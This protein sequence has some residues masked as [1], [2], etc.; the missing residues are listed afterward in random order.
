M[1]FLSYDNHAKQS[2]KTEI[3]GTPFNTSHLFVQTW[4]PD[5]MT[6]ILKDPKFAYALFPW[7]KIINISSIVGSKWKCY[8]AFTGTRLDGLL[9]LSF[10]TQ[11]IIAFIATAPWNYFTVGKMRRI[12]SGFIYF[13]IKTSLYFHQGGEF[14]LNAL[15]DA[16]KFYQSRGMV[17][18]GKVNKEG[19]K[20]YRM[21][22]GRPYPFRTNL[23]S[24]S[25]RNDKEGR[26]HIC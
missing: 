23:R 20:E 7:E 3:L 26:D 14:I 4:V 11:L 5:Y 9:C 24:I 17:A 13:T 25:S 19:F 6:R 1:I 12:G 15:P 18:T 16:E 10:E 8:G 2:C 21:P 22:R